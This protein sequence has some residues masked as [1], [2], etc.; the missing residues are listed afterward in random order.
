F[1]ADQD[2]RRL[3]NGHQRSTRWSIRGCVSIGSSGWASRTSRSCRRS[4]ATAAPPAAARPILAN[5]TEVLWGT[6]RFFSFI[7]RRARV[8]T[9]ARN[10]VLPVGRRRRA[11]VTLMRRERNVQPYY[12]REQ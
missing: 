2:R 3:A 9:R 10:R 7:D 4:R 6:T 1:L 12:D 8:L 11:H 5:R